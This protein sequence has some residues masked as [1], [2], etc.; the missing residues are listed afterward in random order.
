MFVFQEI[1]LLLF[2]LFFWEISSFLMTKLFFLQK[3]FSH[4]RI[5]LHLLLVP[6]DKRGWKS[7]TFIFLDNNFSVKIADHHSITG[8][9]FPWKLRS[10]EKWKKIS[11]YFLPF[12]RQGE[13]GN[14]IE[15]YCVMKGRKK[16]P[17]TRTSR[18][19]H[20]WHLRTFNFIPLNYYSKKSNYTVK[21]VDCPLKS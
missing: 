8:Y 4:K 17:K 12:R 14:K 1:F 20:T 5:F 2:S 3:I 21:V 13:I 7:R 10:L 11:I 9:L 15:L 6:I 19:G 18:T 16:T